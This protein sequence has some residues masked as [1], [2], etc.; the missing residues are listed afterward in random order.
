MFTFHSIAAEVLDYH[1]GSKRGCVGRLR[2][3]G[4]VVTGS[5][6]L[7]CWNFLDVRC[8]L[9]LKAYPDDSHADRELLRD[10]QLDARRRMLVQLRFVEK[11]ILESTLEFIE[12]F[13]T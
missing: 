1:S 12:R 13:K 10:T 3:F 9:L 11:N 6:E 7:L 4:E 2:D 8:R 5:N